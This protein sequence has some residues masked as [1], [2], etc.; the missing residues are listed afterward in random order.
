MSWS[1]KAEICVWINATVCFVQNTSVHAYV[2]NWRSWYRSASSSFISASITHPS[3]H[4]C[5]DTVG[6]V[7]RWNSH[8]FDM[9]YC[10]RIKPFRELQ[11]AGLWSVLSN[12]SRIDEDGISSA[13]QAWYTPTSARFYKHGL[14]SAWFSLFCSICFKKKI[15]ATPDLSNE[16]MK[17]IRFLRND[18]IVYNRDALKWIMGKFGCSVTFKY[19]MFI[20]NF[21]FYSSIALLKTKLTIS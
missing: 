3:E 9:E 12:M 20:I 16:L 17:Q 5:P 2:L 13:A 14:N 21:L 1:L 4:Q 10:V 11:P 18:V 8:S 15:S 19:G 6:T 7:F